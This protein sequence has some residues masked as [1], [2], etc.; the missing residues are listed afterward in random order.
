LRDSTGNRITP[1]LIFDQ[2][3]EVFTLAQ[4]DDFGRARGRRFLDELADLVE[5]RPPKELES[6]FELDDTAT[7]RF[8]FGRSDYRVL[9]ALREDYLAQLESLRQQMPSISQNRVRLAPLTGTQALTAVLKPGR[10]LVSEEVAA[11]VV[12]YVAGGAELANAEVEPSL[13][14]L[15]CR[16]LN[17]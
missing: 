14:S 13:L 16:E 2:F 3:E 1:L 15:I 11:A 12:R 5:N 6:Q 4:G 10:H 17:D 7:E 9:I 8:D